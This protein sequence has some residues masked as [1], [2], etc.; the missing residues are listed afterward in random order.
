LGLNL[1]RGQTHPRIV[2]Y[3]IWLGGFASAALVLALLGQIALRLLQQAERDAA[4]DRVK[5]ADPTITI[6]QDSMI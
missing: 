1:A 6:S 4:V 2:E 3:F 5:K